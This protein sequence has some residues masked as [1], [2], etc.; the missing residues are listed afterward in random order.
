MPAVADCALPGQGLSPASILAKFLLSLTSRCL[1]W[2]LPQSSGSPQPRCRRPRRPERG[3]W[4]APT[5]VKPSYP[6]P[7]WRYRSTR[8]VF[9]RGGCHRGSCP[10]PA[11]K[12]QEELGDETR[13]PFVLFSRA[14]SPA[15]TPSNVPWAAAFWAGCRWRTQANG[16]EVVA[17]RKV[18][19]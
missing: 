18:S 5:P 10:S 19:L 4:P 2:D 17:T 11:V 6:T 16:G 8:F 14:R 9:D 1:R 7:P 13:P 3:R 15:Y 12:H